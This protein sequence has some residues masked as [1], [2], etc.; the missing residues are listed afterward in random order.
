M[1][2][3]QKTQLPG[4]LLV[5]REEEEDE[6]VML[7]ALTHRAWLEDLGAVA[8]ATCLLIGGVLPVPVQEHS[9][10]GAGIGQ[11]R[12]Y[13]D[14]KSMLGQGQP[15]AGDVVGYAGQE[16][17]GT[18]AKE[19]QWLTFSH[20][21]HCSGQWTPLLCPTAPRLVSGPG[22]LQGWGGTTCR[23]PLAEPPGPTA[24]CTAKCGAWLSTPA[25]DPQLLGPE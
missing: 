17:E 7:A 20:T 3:W 2:A 16:W 15:G 5:S 21:Q 24:G 8:T 22:N 14:L 1:A 13:E 23:A 19:Q 12:E 4:M 9:P 18:W 11:E 10:S 6:A 25:R